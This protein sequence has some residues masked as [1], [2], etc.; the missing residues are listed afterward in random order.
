MDKL[1]NLDNNKN[2]LNNK[3]V[4]VLIVDIIPE[5]LIDIGA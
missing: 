1:L 5:V 4:F 3:K 2:S